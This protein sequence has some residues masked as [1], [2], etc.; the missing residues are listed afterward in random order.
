MFCVVEIY[1]PGCFDVLRSCDEKAFAKLRLAA[2]FV[3]RTIAKLGSILRCFVISIEQ[4]CAVILNRATKNI[5]LDQIAA[6][7]ED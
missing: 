6:L 2:L 1:V 3:R 4:S 5:A 7:F